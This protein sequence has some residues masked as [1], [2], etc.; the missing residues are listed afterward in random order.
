[1]KS[2]PA[3]DTFFLVALF[4]MMFVLCGQGNC[5]Q[6]SINRH[7]NGLGAVI[8]YTNPMMYNFGI[9]AD[10]GVARSKDRT[11]TNLRF[12]PYG[13]FELYTEQILLCGPPSDELINKASG[14]IILVYRR[15]A[16]EAVDGIACHDLEGVFSVGAQ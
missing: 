12:Q 14:P 1:M 8:E 3:N 7:S 15:R 6:P 5:E 10:A 13:T 4:F 11:G 9:I 16:H 2:T